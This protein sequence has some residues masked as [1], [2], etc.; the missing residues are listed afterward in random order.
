MKH[1]I[2]FGENGWWY[3]LVLVL[4]LVQIL[5][6]EGSNKESNGGAEETACARTALYGETASDE[7]CIDIYV[8]TST[9]SGGELAPRCQCHGMDPGTGRAIITTTYSCLCW[10]TRVVWP[11]CFACLLVHDTRCFFFLMKKAVIMERMIIQ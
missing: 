6:G 2:R 5:G 7:L 4:A 8:S 1:V 9:S 11:L 10:L 3:V